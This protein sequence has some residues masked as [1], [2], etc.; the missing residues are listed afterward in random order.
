MIR[1]QLPA[2][3]TTPTDPGL[4]RGPASVPQIEAQA[5]S[6]LQRIAELLRRTSVMTGCMNATQAECDA[7][8]P[9]PWT[10]E[11]SLVGVA[12]AD[13]PPRT[14]DEAEQE[15][16]RVLAT[17]SET[18]VREACRIFAS[19]RPDVESESAERRLE[20]ACPGGVWTVTLAGQR[21]Q[22]CDPSGRCAHSSHG[23]QSTGVHLAMVLDELRKR[24]YE[25]ADAMCIKAIAE[26]EME[27]AEARAAIRRTLCRTDPQS[28]GP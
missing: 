5:K 2:L 3:P 4:Q 15:L 26:Q 21:L 9:D 24:I 13:Q 12:T 28:D 14:S 20:V 27:I 16:R 17:H 8:T 25:N 18:I 6:T 23:H 22:I 7:E 10:G 19:V 11:Q 1:D